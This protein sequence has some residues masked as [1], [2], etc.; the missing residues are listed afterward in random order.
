[1][2]MHRTIREMWICLIRIFN[3]RGTKVKISLSCV[4]CWLNF[5]FECMYLHLN[6]EYWM[7]WLIFLIWV[8]IWVFSACTVLN[9]LHQRVLCQQR[10]DL[11]KIRDIGSEPSWC[12][13]F[14]C[15]VKN[16]CTH[17]KLKQRIWIRFVVALIYRNSLVRWCKSKALW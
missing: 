7:L 1:M 15:K 8:L 17:Q 14:C 10:L 9:F 4:K 6:I 2:Y 13:A 11:K 3:L 5:S 12:G 16:R